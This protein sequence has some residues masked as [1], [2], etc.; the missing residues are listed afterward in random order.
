MSDIL[1]LAEIHERFPSEWVL[2]ADPQTDEHLEMLGG[3]VVWHSKDQEEVHRKAI[4]LPAPKHIAVFY[5][6]PMPEDMEYVL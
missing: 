6:G 3:R 5:T 2:L 4:E 1:T